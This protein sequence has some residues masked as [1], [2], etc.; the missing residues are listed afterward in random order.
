MVVTTVKSGAQFTLRVTGVGDDPDCT[1]RTPAPTASASTC[2][3][4]GFSDFLRLAEGVSEEVRR[5]VGSG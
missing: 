5:L 4:C 2:T 1:D 3:F